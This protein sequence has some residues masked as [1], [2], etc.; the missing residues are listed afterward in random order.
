MFLQI[1]GGALASSVIQGFG[2]ALAA[3][4]IDRLPRFYTVQTVGAYPLKRAYDTL[5]ERILERVPLVIDQ[6]F[7]PASDRERAELM[8][9]HPAIVDEELRLRAGTPV[10]VHA[11]VGEA[12][13]QHRA[14]HPGRRDIRL[15][16][17]RR[18]AC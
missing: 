13:A 7:S 18:R 14:R 8:M 9:Q 3:G 17:R 10:R 1:G 4:A 5:A 15:G 12:A 6:G 16:G 2:D 11:A